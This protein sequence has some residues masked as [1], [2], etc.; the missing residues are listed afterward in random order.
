MCRPLNRFVK[1]SVGSS[2]VFVLAY[3][4]GKPNLTRR[5][6]DERTLWYYDQ[7]TLLCDSNT[8]SEDF[9]WVKLTSDIQFDLLRGIECFENIANSLGDICEYEYYEALDYVKRQF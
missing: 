2:R 4:L 6:R 8:S 9:K 3:A 1:K 7:L 5:I